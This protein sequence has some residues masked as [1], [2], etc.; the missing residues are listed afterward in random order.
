MI[1]KNVVVKADNGLHARPAGLL[2]KTASK[3]NSEIS[4]IVNGKKA[5]AKS[6]ISIMSLGVK[7]NEEVTIVVKGEDEALAIEEVANI[8][9]SA[10]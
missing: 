9:E 7:E 10:K 3:Y 8:L 1:E 4:L 2:V 5:N 6:I